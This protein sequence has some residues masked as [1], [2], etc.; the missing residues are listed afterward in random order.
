M[1]INAVYISVLLTLCCLDRVTAQKEYRVPNAQ[2]YFVGIKAGVLTTWPVFTDP[3]LKEAYSSSP[4]GGFNVAGLINFSLKKHYSFQSEFGYSQLGRSVSFNSG[5]WSN[6]STYQMLDFSVLLRRS[7]RLKIG[8]DIPANWYFNV[9]PNIKYWLSG[10]GEVSSGSDP[11]PYTIVFNGTPSGEY[12]KLYYQDPNRWLF[13]LD[14]GLGAN[15]GT[16]KGQQVMAEL[17]FTYGHTFLGNK[18]SAGP[19]SINLLGFDDS[20][21]CNLKVLTFSLSYTLDFYTGQAKMGK[22]THQSI[23]KKK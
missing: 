19:Q 14:F 13:G 10:K 4:V 23:R 21:L 9:G 17:R 8:K 1:K 15:L 6:T 11:L 5:T 18:G 12:N 7:F 2:R 22:S 3:D 20:L 16:A